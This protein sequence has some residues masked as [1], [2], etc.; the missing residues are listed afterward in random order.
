MYEWDEDKR[1]ANIVKHGVDFAAMDAFQWD[2]AV[3]AFDHRHGEPRWLATGFIDLQLHV[4]AYA[5]RGDVVRI[6]SL[7]RATPQE[8]RRHG[9]TRI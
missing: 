2:T 4:V 7:R 5:V 3:G 6:I 9:E 8:R 1:Q